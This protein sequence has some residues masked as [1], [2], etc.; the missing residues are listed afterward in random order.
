MQ[1]LIKAARGF[2]SVTSFRLTHLLEWQLDMLGLAG[3]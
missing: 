2:I 3:K 1:T